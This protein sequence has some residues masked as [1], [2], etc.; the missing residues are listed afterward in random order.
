MQNT[1]D[2]SLVSIDIIPQLLTKFTIKARLEVVVLR[3]CVD[4]QIYVQSATSVD[5]ITNIRYNNRKGGV[6]NDLE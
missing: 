1:Y 5:I 3:N 2:N 6:D 4:L